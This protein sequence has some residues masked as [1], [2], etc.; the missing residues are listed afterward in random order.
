MVI[1]PNSTGFNYWS[2]LP[3]KILRK[4]YLFNLTNAYQVEKGIEPPHLSQIG[5]YV[6]EEIWERHNVE[7]VSEKLVH[8]SPV[9]KFIF[10]PDLSNGTLNDSLTFLNVPALVKK[11]IR[12]L[13]YQV[14]N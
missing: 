6:Y 13:I 14:L 4:Y 8:S 7:F 5:P 10:Q 11:K 3:V 9:Q 2:K 1:G 12:F